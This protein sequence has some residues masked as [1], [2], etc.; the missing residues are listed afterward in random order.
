MQTKGD[1]CNFVSCLPNLP[2]AWPSLCSTKLWRFVGKEVRETRRRE[3]GNTC[4]GATKKPEISRTS[5]ASHKST[6]L[7]TIFFFE[8]SHRQMLGTKNVNRLVWSRDVYPT[9]HAQS[10]V[11]RRKD[12][13]PQ[14]SG[15]RVKHL[16]ADNEF[17]LVVIA[18]NDYLREISALHIVG[19]YYTPQVVMSFCDLYSCRTRICLKKC[20]RW[21]AHYRSWR[22]RSWTRSLTPPNSS[23]D[24][25]QPPFKNLFIIRCLVVSALVVMCTYRQNLAP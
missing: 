2:S 11:S 5:L 18:S 22:T 23:F 4:G 13:I 14:H 20:V 24:F 17:K 6:L 9:P 21:S 25:W 19:N 12:A 16:G 15:W 8:T 3:R 7:S 10:L 1:S